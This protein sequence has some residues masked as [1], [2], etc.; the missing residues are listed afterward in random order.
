MNKTTALRRLLKKKEFVY[1]PVAYDALGG[2]LLQ[3]LGFDC[4]YTGGFVTGA[5]RCTSEPLLTMDEQLRMAGDVA[6]AIE[7]PLVVDGGAGFGE[8]L[9]TMRTV[10]ECI[11]AGIAGAHIEDQLYPKRAHYHKYVAHAVPRKEFAD[12]IRFACKQRDRSDADFVVIART[13]TCRFEGL[14]EAIA[15][16]NMAADAGADLGL[17][18]PRNDAEMKKAPKQARI[19][20]V[21]VTSRGNRDGRPVPTAAQ[22]ADMGYKAAIDAMTYL[23]ASFH[24]TKLAYGEI[25][26]TGGYTGLTPKQCVAARHE[27]ETLVGLDAFYEIEEQ[28]VEKKLNTRAA[29]RRLP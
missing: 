28:T 10:R 5:S 21:Y 1:M 23:L 19:P 24:F 6:A 12:K 22:L 8:P 13:D 9:H 17:L 11:R 25:K 3:S 4:V 26:R 18:F 27:I 20:L 15:R 2:R 14:K 16:V 29:G 7:I